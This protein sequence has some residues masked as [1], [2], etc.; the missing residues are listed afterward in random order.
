MTSTTPR[1]SPA[2]SRP[3]PA[4]TSSSRTWTPRGWSWTWTRCA[5][6]PASSAPSTS[7]STCRFPA[8]IAPCAPGYVDHVARTLDHPDPEA[9]LKGDEARV[10]Q[11]IRNWHAERLR[12]LGF[13]H[14]TRRVVCVEANNSPLYDVVLASRHPR[15]VDLFNKANRLDLTGQMGLGL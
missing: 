12:E 1:T 9:L 11:A 14:I 6:W 5:S 2:L 15:A 3:S 10:T 4:A 7:S 8:S 13:E